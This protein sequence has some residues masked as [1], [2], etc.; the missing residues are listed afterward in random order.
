MILL[1]IVSTYDYM[2]KSIYAAMYLMT[3]S[4]FIIWLMVNDPPVKHTLEQVE[5]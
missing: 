2:A 5:H 1:V 3:G 4:L